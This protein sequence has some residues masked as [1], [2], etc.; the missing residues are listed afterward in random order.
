M[1]ST[2][3][4]MHSIKVSFNGETRRLQLSEGVGGRLSYQALVG[5]IQS[6]FPSL[7]NGAIQLQYEDDEGDFITLSTDHELE[8]AVR[9]M[10]TL[11]KESTSKILKFRIFEAAV[12]ATATSTTT[13]TSTSIFH[14][15]RKPSDE[16]KPQQKPHENN[17][18]KQQENNSEVKHTNITCDGC[19]MFP[20]VGIRYKS[21]VQEDFDL[22]EGCEAKGTHPFPLLKISDP[23]QAPAVL[24]YGFADGNNGHRPRHHHHGHHHGKRQSWMPFW[25]PPPANPHG[26]P[27]PPPHPNGVPPPRPFFGSGPPPRRS[28]CRMP[29]PG[30]RWRHF[31]N[32]NNNENEHVYVNVKATA[33]P[34]VAAMDSHFN[35]SCT[36][37]FSTEKE[38]EKEVE[39]EDESDKFSSFATGLAQKISDVTM[40]IVNANLFDDNNNNKEE[41]VKPALRFV[42]HVTYPDGTLVQPGGVFNKTWRVR[43]DGSQTWPD[44]V[45]LVYNSGDVLTEQSDIARYPVNDTVPVGGEI[46][47]TIQLKAPECT[48]RF[49]SYFRMQTKD[50]VKFGQRLWADV[51]VSDDETDWHVVR[52]SKSDEI[53]RETAE[54]LLEI[55][56][57]ENNSVKSDCEDVIIPNVT[58]VSENI[59]EDETIYDVA[60][61]LEV[62]SNI[63]E[64]DNNVSITVDSANTITETINETNVPEKWIKELM[65]LGEMGFTDRDLLIPLLEE[66]LDN[67]NYSNTEGMQRVVATLLSES[68]FLH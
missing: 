54:S 46:D 17:Q 53:Q 37:S 65:L 14:E 50:E 42:R 20:I 41:K 60:P 6:V 16:T 35:N 33:S 21:A 30:E 59:V 23:S 8:E 7:T 44:G 22:C 45:S 68:G 1:I 4:N 63:V 62:V 29:P 51:I 11:N 28:G 57:S 40:S 19:G 43:N 55:E 52:L 10:Y 32:N 48:G 2:N 64:P 13:T 3:I 58:V 26:P 12:S 66:N 24:L 25:G 49:I 61:E 9:V 27:P 36:S 67:N 38:A 5:V 31:S 56:K 39:K 47:I 15:E 34:F 18:E